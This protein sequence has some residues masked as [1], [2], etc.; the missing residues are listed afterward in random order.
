MFYQNMRDIS[1]MAT[2]YALDLTGNGMSSRPPFAFKG[3]KEVGAAPLYFPRLHAVD[4]SLRACMRVCVEIL[5]AVLCLARACLCA[6][7]C[8]SAL[9]SPAVPVPACV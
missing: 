5:R 9:L 6:C 2:V 4:V 8:L 1:R 3:V 7:V